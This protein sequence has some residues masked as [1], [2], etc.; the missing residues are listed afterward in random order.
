MTWHTVPCEAAS[1]CVKV[2]RMGAVV[3]IGTTTRPGQITVDR[4][5]WDAFVAAIRDGWNPPADGTRE[6]GGQA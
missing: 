3:R 4:A 6:Q 2:R 5:E 1:A